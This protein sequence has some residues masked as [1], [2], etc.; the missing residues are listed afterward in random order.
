M[1]LPTTL[2]GRR[3][4]ALPLALF[5]LVIAAV[6][7]T[8]VFYVGRLEQRMGTNS[9]AATQAFEA[10]ETGVAYV[11]THWTPSYSSIASGATTVLPVTAVGSNATYTASIRRL[12]TTL[13]LL[14]AEGRFLVAGQAVTRRQVARVIRLDPPV[15]E[16]A[17]ALTTR[18]GLEVTDDATIDGSDNVPGTWGITCAAPF[19][20]VAAI[21]DSAGTVVTTPN[22]TGQTCLTGS[23]TIQTTAFGARMSVYNTF[24]SETFSSL[25]TAAE[26]VV[27]GTISGIAPST[28]PGSPPT[29][30]TADPNNWG[31][32][33]DPTGRCGNYFPIIYA[34]GDL[35]LSS[36]IGQGVLLVQGNLNI[37]GPFQFYGIIIVQGV[38]T[39]SNGQVYGA[40]M[41]ASD[42]GVPSGRIGGTAQ[43][44]YSHCAVDRAATGAAQPSAIRER[45]WVQLY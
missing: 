30:N 36:G 37:S 43:L 40:V 8:A 16:P 21:V 45:S 35:E 28:I 39:A 2:A 19:P 34:P 1:T 38:V 29:C 12:N 5:T 14:Q 32:A 23:P 24:G 7:I 31:D 18:L 15:I 25:A 3:G 44:K 42:G 10:A 27:S 11:L 22:C 26:K 33:V 20:P 6:M 13:F 4:V 41:T 9:V 17:G